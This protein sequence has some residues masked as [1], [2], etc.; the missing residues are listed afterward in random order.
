RAC[1][2]RS[3]AARPLTEAGKRCSYGRPGRTSG[4]S[5]VLRAIQ[6]TSGP[7]GRRSAGSSAWPAAGREAGSSHRS[8]TPRPGRSSGGSRPC[9]G[10]PF[11]ALCQAGLV[12][13]ARSWPGNS[14][15]PC[16][17]HAWHAE[18]SGRDTGQPPGLVTFLAEEGEGEVDA[19]DF[20]EPALLLGAAPAGLEVAF[21]LVEAG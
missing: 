17:D 9:D 6:R 4:R 16:G 5:P 15:C 18:V 11:S 13:M 2:P 12:G 19:L 1:R 7:P 3:P 21:D 20:T 10:A 14:W 8:G